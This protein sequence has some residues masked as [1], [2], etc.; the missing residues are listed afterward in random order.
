MDW[1]FLKIKKKSIDPNPNQR[2]NEHTMKSF[3]KN[4]SIQ[5]NLIND[6]MIFDNY[7]HDHHHDVLLC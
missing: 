5:K 6:M 4:I 1:L 2:I 3:E 7:H